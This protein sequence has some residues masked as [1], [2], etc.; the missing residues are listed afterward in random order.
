MH[1]I[2]IKPNIQIL[3]KSKNLTLLMKV[4]LY[5][6]TFQQSVKQKASQHIH[7]T[8]NHLPRLKSFKTGLSGGFNNEI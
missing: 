3:H 6:Y 7:T 5:L 1:N 2:Y 8:T 4:S